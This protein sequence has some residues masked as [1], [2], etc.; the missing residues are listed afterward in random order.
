MRLADDDVGCR[1]L[2]AQRVGQGRAIA[3]EPWPETGALRF[4]APL[5]QVGVVHDTHVG[6]RRLA[7]AVHVLFLERHENQ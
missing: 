2:V 1:K 5:P 7:D 6:S 3:P 4:G